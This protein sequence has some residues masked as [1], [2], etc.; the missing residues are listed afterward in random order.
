MQ[1][2]AEMRQAR[3]HTATSAVYSVLG[4]SRGRKRGSGG[5]TASR[6]HGGVAGEEVGGC[7]E[8]GLKGGGEEGGVGEQV[9]A[10]RVVKSA[11]GERFGQRN[12]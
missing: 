7:G 9:V 11:Q 12:C 4:H 1:Y 3:P 10:G 8:G 2:I 6:D 5:R